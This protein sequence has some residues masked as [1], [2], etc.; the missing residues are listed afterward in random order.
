LYVVE[1]YARDAMLDLDSDRKY[2]AGHSGVEAG[3]EAKA[4]RLRRRQ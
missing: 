4:F 1:E 3:S 2:F